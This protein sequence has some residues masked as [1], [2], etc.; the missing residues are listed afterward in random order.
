[1]PSRLTSNSPR[2]PS[3]PTSNS[4]AFSFLK[5]G[6][7]Y[8]SLAGLELRGLA[9]KCHMP[10]VNAG[11]FLSVS[12]HWAYFLWQQPLLLFLSCSDKPIVLEFIFNLAYYIFTPISLFFALYLSLQTSS[13][14]QLPL[15]GPLPPP[16]N[17]PLPLSDVT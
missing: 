15:P 4:L 8:V 9:L 2:T 17:P 10:C 3:T 5:T 7:L 13:P 11:V 14:L 6:F 16:N 12:S 1:M